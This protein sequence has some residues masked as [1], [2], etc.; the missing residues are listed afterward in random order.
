MKKVWFLTLLVP[1]FLN[2][3]TLEQELDALLEN[4]SLSEVVQFRGR[5]EGCSFHSDKAL[6]QGRRG[7]QWRRN[8]AFLE[9]I[10]VHGEEETVRFYTRAGFVSPARD[11]RNRY[12]EYSDADIKRLRFVLSARQLGFSIEDIKQIVDHADSECSPCPIVRR[13]ID[14][15]LYETEQRFLE[16]QK[17]RERMQRAVTE[18]SKKPDKAPTG[19]M[20]CHL[21][22]EFTTDD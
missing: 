3:M 22:E 13:L 21:I 5:P 18:W 19:N 6:L 14:Q 16:T 9:R 20:L 1:F 4:L 8:G 17:L 2:C 7:L 12:R 11:Q 15:R 10:L